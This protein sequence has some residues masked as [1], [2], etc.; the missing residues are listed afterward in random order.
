M[1]KEINVALHFRGT[2]GLKNP[3][4]I[5]KNDDEYYSHI[6][7]KLL[8]GF[9]SASFRCAITTTFCHQKQRQ[10]LVLIYYVWVYPEYWFIE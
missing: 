8:H 4:F 9:F 6:S 1:E 3:E 7:L 10:N 2:F 5:S